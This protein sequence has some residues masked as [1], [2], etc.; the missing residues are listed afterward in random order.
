MTADAPAR[1]LSG[2]PDRARLL[3]HLREHPASP[4]ELADDLPLSHRSVQRNLARFVERGWAEKRDGDYRLTTTGALVAERHGAYVGSLDRIDRFAPVLRHLPDAE[5][6]PDPDWLRDADL[7]AATPDTPQAPVN[8][9]VTAVK[10]FSTDRIRMIAPVLSR[11]YHE[12]HA[13][14][15][16]RGVET[17]LVMD[18]E[19]IAS[20]RS[21]NPAE[22]AFVVRVPRFSLYEHPGPIR[23]GLTL[24]DDRALL[25]AYDGEG[26]LRAVLDCADADFLDWAAALYERYRNDSERLTQ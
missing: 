20:A 1:F 13:G 2:S 15:V 26:G 24:G 22:F 8:H 10:S 14:L 23:F 25:G 21:L 17:E 3:S 16:L 7:A 18:A 12:A 6:A 5:H 4:S 11:L 19:T 9:Y